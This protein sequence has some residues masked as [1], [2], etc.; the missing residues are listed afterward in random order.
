MVLPPQLLLYLTLAPEEKTTYKDGGPAAVATF[1]GGVQAFLS[2]S[3][4][5]MQVVTSDPFEVTEEVEAI[6]MLQRSTQ[7]GEFY[8]MGCPPTGLSMPTLEGEVLKGFLDII[9]FDEEGDRHAVV[10]FDTAYQACMVEELIKKYPEADT[11]AGETPITLDDSDETRT[12]WLAKVRRRDTPAST[13]RTAA[14]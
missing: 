11:D 2:R 5:G 8:I 10:N 12:S 1:E 4:R 6:Q 14:G 13:P 7:V 9:I 3:F